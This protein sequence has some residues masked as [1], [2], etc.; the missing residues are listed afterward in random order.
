M[1][2][3]SRLLSPQLA[4]LAGV[5]AGQHVLDV[6]CGPGALLTELVGRLGADAVAGVDPSESYVAA[7]RERHPGVDI[8]VAPA[9]A[10]PFTDGSFDAALAQLVV[11]FMSDPV[12]GLREM[13]RVS[14]AGGVVAACVWDYAGHHDPLRVF[15][16][17]ARER[18]PAVGD[19]SDLAGVR[20]GHLAELLTAAG[21]TE[22]A[23]GALEVR[24]EQPDF[25][26]WW[27]PFTEGVGPAGAYL[28]RLDPTARDAL[29][30]AC[31]EMLPAG[32]FALEAR[33]WAARGVVA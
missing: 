26:T 22:I 6:G 1:G 14:R 5:R 9:E 4:D 16:A 17:A 3:W 10:L 7:A 21:L 27:Q 13:A 25:E 12:A 2:R 28:A 15:W 11:H 20:E 19:E 33:A 8:R 30:E 24:L 18:D 32:P 29:R 31:R 23:S